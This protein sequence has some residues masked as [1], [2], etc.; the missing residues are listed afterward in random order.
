MASTKVTGP[1]IGVRLEASFGSTGL[2]EPL[3]SRVWSLFSHHSRHF[4]GLAIWSSSIS[5]SV[6]ITNGL[7]LILSELCTMVASSTKIPRG[8]VIITLSFGT[9]V[10]IVVLYSD[11]LRRTAASGITPT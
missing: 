9:A 11:R 2:S 1:L 10:R 4:P 7:S 5:I 8:T 6:F 3:T